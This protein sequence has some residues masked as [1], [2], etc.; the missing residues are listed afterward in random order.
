MIV[1]RR[2]KGMENKCL[3]VVSAEEDEK[4]LDTNGD[5]CTTM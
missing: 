2:E 3:Y 1:A 4:V 5:S